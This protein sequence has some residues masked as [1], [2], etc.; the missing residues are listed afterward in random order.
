MSLVSGPMLTLQQVAAQIGHI[1]ED[2]ISGVL[3]AF[4]SSLGDLLSDQGAFLQAQHLLVKP[5]LDIILK[6]AFVTV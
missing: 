4:E 6:L 2:C 5:W 3:H 1:F